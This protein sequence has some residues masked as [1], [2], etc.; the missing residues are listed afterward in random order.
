MLGASLGHGDVFTYSV[1][2]QICGCWQT[3]FFADVNLE[4]S[5]SLS[6]P[7]VNNVIDSTLLYTWIVLRQSHFVT[8]LEYTSRESKSKN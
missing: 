2:S 1:G 7:D 8:C 6:T 5:R 4:V 3:S